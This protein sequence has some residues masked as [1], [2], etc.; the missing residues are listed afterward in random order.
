M[1]PRESQAVRVSEHVEKVRKRAKQPKSK[2]ARDLTHQQR[3]EKSRLA[4]DRKKK[5]WEDIRAE[6]ARQEI[7]CKE[8]VNRHGVKPEY[9]QKYMQHLPK[10]GQQRGINAYNVE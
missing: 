7:V 4:A 8:H 5:L 3:Q 2:G 9:V 6:W 10:Y 1:A